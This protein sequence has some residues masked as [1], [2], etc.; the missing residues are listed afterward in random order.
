VAPTLAVA[1]LASVLGGTGN[2]VQWVAVMT[3]LQ[4]SVEPD[5]QA[6]AAGLLESA[7]AAVPGIGYLVG[8]ALTAAVSPR[9]AYAVSAVGV[10]VVVALWARRPI[11]PAGVGVG[12]A[13][14]P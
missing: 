12:G 2:G 4:E 14:G 3:A 8:G 13:A 11:V 7:L 5:Y 1:C 6:R 10:A 9:L